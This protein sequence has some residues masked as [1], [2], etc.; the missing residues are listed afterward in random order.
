[1]LPDCCSGQGGVTVMVNPGQDIASVIV[2]SVTVVVT[3]TQLGSGFSS[4]SKEKRG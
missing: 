4:V 3:V 1:M 2:V